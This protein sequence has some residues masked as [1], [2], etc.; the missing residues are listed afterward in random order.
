V[1][2]PALADALGAARLAALR[3]DCR[4]CELGLGAAVEGHAAG[5]AWLRRADQ[6]AVRLHLGRRWARGRPQVLAWGRLAH[7]LRR[8]GLQAR[9]R[10]RPGPLPSG[11][12][13]LGRAARARAL[14]LGP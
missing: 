5:G 12:A 9:A 13:R 14:V 11:G 8:E 4:G 7:L 1:R 3:L 6:L 10:P 2:V